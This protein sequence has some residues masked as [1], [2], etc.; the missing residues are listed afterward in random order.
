LTKHATFDLATAFSA[1]RASST[2]MADDGI[3]TSLALKLVATEIKQMADKFIVS[4]DGVRKVTRAL[5]LMNTETKARCRTEV[6][7]SV[8]EAVAQ[9]KGRVPRRTDELADT[10]RGV[11]ANGDSPVGWLQAGFGSL[12][13]RSR[14]RTVKGQV[15]A[16][17]KAK[18]QGPIEPGI[19]AMVVEFGD[20]LRNKPAEPYINPAVEATRPHHEARIATALKG[21]VAAAES[22]T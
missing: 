3:W 7:A 20:A 1:L 18:Q 9:A 8:S 14:S 5:Q 11:M 4:I 10:I 21:A 17:Q 19:Y 15:R 6:Q 12:K 2:W 16:R 13:R 22:G